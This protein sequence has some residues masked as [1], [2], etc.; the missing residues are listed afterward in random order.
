MTRLWRFRGSR[1]VVAGAPA[2][3]AA[4]DPVEAPPGLAHRSV[5][6]QEIAQPDPI[7]LLWH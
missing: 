2:P 1:S 3:D 6:I 5:A 4:G 7:L